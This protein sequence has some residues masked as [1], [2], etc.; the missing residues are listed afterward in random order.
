MAEKKNRL[1]RSA[2]RDAARGDDAAIGKF[3]GEG[4]RATRKKLT[5]EIDAKLIRDLKRHGLDTD[6]PLWQLVERYCRE[7]LERD[8][9]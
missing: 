3:L 9:P 5:I 8:T 6:A 1:A 4:D 2:K 7:G